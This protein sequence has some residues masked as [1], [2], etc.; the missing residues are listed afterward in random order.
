MKKIHLQF[1]KKFATKNDEKSIKK[2][3]EKNYEVISIT[4]ILLNLIIIAKSQ[5]HAL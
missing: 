1:N 5:S 3:Y 4:C 2:E